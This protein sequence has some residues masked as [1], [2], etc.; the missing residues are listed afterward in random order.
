MKIKQI[1]SVS[2]TWQTC[3]ERFI[4]SHNDLIGYCY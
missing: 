2:N 1:N 3:T 4:R